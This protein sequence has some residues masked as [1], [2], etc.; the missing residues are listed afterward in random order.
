[1]STITLSSGASQETHTTMRRTAVGTDV[2]ALAREALCNNNEQA[3]EELIHTTEPWLRRLFRLR[4]SGAP[5]L[6]V[7]PEDL[8]QEFW[9]RVTQG[10]YI[11]SKPFWPWA[12]RIALHLFID[13]VRPPHPPPVVPLPPNLP[14]RRSSAVDIDLEAINNSLNPEERDIIFKRNWE[15]MS[16]AEI[17]KSRSASI[18]SVRSKWHR[19][20]VR[21]RKCLES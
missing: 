7:E 6:G 9:I 8:E 10:K 20:K 18:G 19:A 17:A 14:V 11:P 15:G 13:E 5:S 4:L 16:W 21:L 2:D 12:Q 3:L 1:M